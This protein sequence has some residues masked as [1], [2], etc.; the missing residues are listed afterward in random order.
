MAREENNEARNENKVDEEGP[1]HHR[2]R[3][4]YVMSIPGDIA[5]W[6][7]RFTSCEGD[8]E[9][10]SPFWS[11]FNFAFCQFLRRDMSQLKTSVYIQP[12]HSSPTATSAR[13]KCPLA[14]CSFAPIISTY[15][16]RKISN[17]TVDS[18]RT[19]SSFGRSSL[20]PAIPF[21]PGLRGRL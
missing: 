20:I 5:E 10:S 12:T 17:L 8:A 11:N 15:H 21:G 4:C 6:A 14:L 1:L 2:G 7:K 18:P 16:S 3:R 19:G 13:M 9:F